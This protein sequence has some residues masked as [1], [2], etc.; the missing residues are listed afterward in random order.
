VERIE[1]SVLVGFYDIICNR[2]SARQIRKVY[3][4]N[5]DKRKQN[6]G[7]VLK[8]DIL[9]EIFCSEFFRIRMSTFKT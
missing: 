4:E 1:G 6:W 2:I 3:Q 5:A 7:Q 8:V 9:N